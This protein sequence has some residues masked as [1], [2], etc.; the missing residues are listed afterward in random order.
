[1]SAALFAAML[2]VPMGLALVLIGAF[3]RRLK[4][5][6]LGAASFGLGLLLY[7]STLLGEFG[8]ADACLDAGGR[9]NYDNRVCELP[10][11]P[12]PEARP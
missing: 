3:R 6:L 4:I 11:P 8:A 7:F 2:L 1:M 9:W 12:A 5:Q 10:D